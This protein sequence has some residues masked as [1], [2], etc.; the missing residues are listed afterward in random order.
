MIT[1]AK[2]VTRHFAPLKKRV[3]RDYQDHVMKAHRGVETTINGNT[4]SSREV[5]AIGTIETPAARGFKVKN[6]QSRLHPILRIESQKVLDE[7]ARERGLNDRAE[8]I[9]AA[10]AMRNPV[11][12]APA[13]PDAWRAGDDIEAELEY[14]RKDE[15]YEAWLAKERADMAARRAAKLSQV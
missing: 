1:K 3:V 13:I 8:L 5:R 2:V 4:G 12:S 10:E 14:L 15:A 9:A 11:K 6:V 7:R